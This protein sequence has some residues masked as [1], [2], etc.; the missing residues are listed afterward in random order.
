[1]ALS[2]R[3]RGREHDTIFEKWAMIRQQ[4]RVEDYIK[5]FEIL[6]S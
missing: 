6:V 4:E 1:V 5:E 3:F 2:R